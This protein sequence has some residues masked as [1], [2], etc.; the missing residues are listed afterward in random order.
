[1][2]TVQTGYTET[3]SEGAPGLIVNPST[4]DVASYRYEGEDAGR[5]GY[6]VARGS[7]DRQCRADAFF[8]TTILGVL[9]MDKT[10]T[11]DQDDEYAEG[12]VASVLYRGTV[13]VRVGASVEPGD[14]VT[15]NSAT[16]QFSTGESGVGEIVVTNGGSGY[17]GSPTAALSGG[18][19][20]VDAAIR[21]TQKSGQSVS[22]IRLTSSGSGYQTEP[23]VVISGGGGS[24]AKAYAVLDRIPVAGAQWLTSAKANGLAQLRMSGVPASI[25]R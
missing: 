15:V 25:N 23:T 16:G 11:P 9:V 19:A 6:A 5:F 18:R 8:T 24:G 12:D 22:R 20:L 14:P 1:M 13:W 4:S 21:D 10:L 3:H 7:S 2:A 17:S